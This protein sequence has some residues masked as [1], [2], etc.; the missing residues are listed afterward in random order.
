MGGGYESAEIT[1][2]APRMFRETV[3]MT[4]LVMSVFNVF[5]KDSFMDSNVNVGTQKET[6]AVVL[7]HYWRG[8]ASGYA[9]PGHRVEPHG[10]RGVESRA[11]EEMCLVTVEPSTGGGQ[12]LG[13]VGRMVCQKEALVDSETRGRTAWPCD[14]AS[15]ERSKL[16]WRD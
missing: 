14:S 8:P 4:F 3:F 9:V 13:F 10:L 15:M 1:A 7:Q 11:D 2:G 16:V 5:F 12:E 6:P